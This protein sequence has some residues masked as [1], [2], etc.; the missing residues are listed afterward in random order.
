[1]EHVVLVCVPDAA[2]TESVAPCGTVNGVVSSPSLVTSYLLT[3]DQGSFFES[4]NQP[5]DY[6]AAAGFWGAAFTGTL[7]LWGIAKSA[8]MVLSFIKQA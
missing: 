6:T 2:L 8:G 5:F 7:L 1:M 3:P 4:L